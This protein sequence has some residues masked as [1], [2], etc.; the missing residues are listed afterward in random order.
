ML[1]AVRLLGWLEWLRPLSKS[2]RCFLQHRWSELPSLGLSG[3]ILSLGIFPKKKNKGYAAALSLPTGAVAS[4]QVPLVL[5]G[6]P[7]P[8]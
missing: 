8:P 7:Q 1:S 2:R 5:A 4:L 6:S 3:P